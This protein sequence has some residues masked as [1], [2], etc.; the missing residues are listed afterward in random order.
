VMLSGVCCYFVIQLSAVLP[1]DTAPPRM[2]LILLTA[3]NPITL[4]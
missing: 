1:D 2:L 3:N 4:C